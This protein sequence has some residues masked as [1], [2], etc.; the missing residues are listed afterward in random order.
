MGPNVTRGRRGSVLAVV[1][2]LNTPQSFHTTRISESHL[3]D[4]A[5]GGAMAA[6]LGH[7]ATVCGPLG[8]QVFL[9][10]LVFLPWAVILGLLAWMLRGPS[11]TPR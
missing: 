6:L 10:G 9:W 2:A 5:E 11:R 7:I 8:T 3:E 4:G 1:E